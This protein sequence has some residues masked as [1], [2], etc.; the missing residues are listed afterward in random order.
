MKKIQL[1]IVGFALLATQQL[2][3]QKADTLAF[4]D[5]EGAMVDGI[6]DPYAF[7]VDD[8]VQGTARAWVKPN[9]GNTVNILNAKFSAYR[10]GFDASNAPISFY[11]GLSR[12]A[13][14]IF[15][16]N[17]TASV[18]WRKKTLTT[19]RYWYL[20]NISTV[21]F[22]QVNASIYLTCAGTTGPGKFRFGFKIG[23]GQWID[24]AEFK[25]VRGGVTLSGNFVGSDPRDLWSHNLPAL[26]ANQPKISV[27]WCSNDLRA[28]NVQ[29]ISSTGYSRVDNVSATGVKIADFISNTHQKM[30]LTVDGNRIVASSTVNI[31]L[32]NLQGVCLKKIQLS[33]GET[34]ILN[35]GC[36]IIKTSS[37][38]MK[39]IVL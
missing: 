21:G 20:E 28:D 24:D 13:T 11:Q 18:E 16:N 37:G 15:G 4:W 23:D 32:Y 6:M 1:I 29:D 5:F 10:E 7:Y 34:A 9:L 30:G 39:A 38:V 22:E 25:D 3:A 19:V 36:Y 27:R 2:T 17:G 14:T 8:E 33:E 26:C 12:T 31:I 35:K